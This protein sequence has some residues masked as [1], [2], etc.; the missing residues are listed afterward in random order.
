MFL[1]VADGLSKLMQK[2][3]QN[4]NLHELHICRRAPGISHL[5]SVDDTLIFMEATENQAEIIKSIIRVYE[6]GTGQL[7]NLSK[8]SMLFGALCPST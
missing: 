5:L 8:C 3:V 1:F 2:E 6:G 4:G 7:V